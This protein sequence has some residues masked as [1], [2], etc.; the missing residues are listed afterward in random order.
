MICEVMDVTRNL[1]GEVRWCVVVP[2]I[3]L[4]IAVNK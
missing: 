4:S 1:Q 3:K 2:P